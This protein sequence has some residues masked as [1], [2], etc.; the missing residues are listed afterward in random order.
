MIG[1]ELVFS[2]WYGRRRTSSALNAFEAIDLKLWF[3]TRRK[4]DRAELSKKDKNT[5]SAQYKTNHTT[6]HILISTVAKTDL[7]IE[8][9]DYTIQPKHGT[10][11]HKMAA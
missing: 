8:S 7:Q 10:D 6:P 1:R 3:A 2:T 5:C 4:R 9:R 11:I